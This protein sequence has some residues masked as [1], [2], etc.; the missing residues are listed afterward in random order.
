MLA[1]LYYLHLKLEVDAVVIRVYFDSKYDVKFTFALT[2]IQLVAI[3]NLFTQ[4]CQ[5]CVLRE[6]SNQQAVV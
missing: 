3:T 2:Y 4:K 1:F 5:L 6:N